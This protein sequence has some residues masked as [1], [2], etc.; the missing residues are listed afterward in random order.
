MEAAVGP[1]RSAAQAL[2]YWRGRL[3]EARE[4]VQD[5]GDYADLEKEAWVQRVETVEYSK[6]SECLVSMAQHSFPKGDLLLLRN[7][8]RYCSVTLSVPSPYRARLQLS[9][10]NTRK[11]WD[12]LGG[13]IRQVADDKSRL[14]A[15]RLL[16]NL[17]TQHTVN[18]HTFLSVWPWQPPDGSWQKDR[19]EILE[20][21]KDGGESPS[22]AAALLPQS[23]C[24]CDLLLATTSHRPALAALV[25]A[26]YNALQA[27]AKDKPSLLAATVD[28]LCDSPLLIVNLLRHA[29]PATVVSSSATSKAADEATEW[30]G[31]LLGCACRYGSVPSLYTS[32]TGQ[33][34]LSKDGTAPNTSVWNRIVPEQVV[35]LQMLLA[36]VEESQ[37]DASLWIL[38]ESTERRHAHLSFLAR[39]LYQDLRRG[40]RESL[41]SSRSTSNTLLE[42]TLA[43][44][45]TAMSLIRE[46]LAQVLGNGSS[47]GQN[48]RESL[49]PTTVEVF[50]QDLAYH[51]DAVQDRFVGRPARDVVLTSEEQRTLVSSIR[52]VGHLCH[53]CRKHQDLL[54]TTVVPLPTASGDDTTHDAGPPVSSPQ[55]QHQRTALHVLLSCTS[56]SHTCFTLREWS[57]VTI[58]HALEDNESNQDL[59]AQLEAQQAAPAAALDDMG[60]RMQLQANGKVSLEPQ[61]PNQ[62]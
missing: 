5:W 9:L 2:Q 1:V 52:L 19:T 28:T 58:R 54:R 20:P 6:A 27:T 15:T 12:V 37:G 13:V 22:R 18:S 17:V 50:L 53:G 43:L 30:V 61:E 47:Q 59:V 7:L 3:T 11:L 4:V 16:C 62:H 25:A 31:Y 46:V 38:G 33:G 41:G 42:T 29:L 44:A 48:L 10:G 51:Y 49:A 35:L 45:P 23:V 57:V 34:K 36:Q 60:L 8:C 39:A 55:Q 14:L 32:A 40:Y 21:E 26:W 24:G 56:L